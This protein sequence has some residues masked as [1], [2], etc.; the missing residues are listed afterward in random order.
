MA[1]PDSSPGWSEVVSIAR[2]Y[3]RWLCVAFLLPVL[4]AV[5]YAFLVT[6][7]YQADSKVLIR[8]GREYEPHLDGAGRNVALPT[9]TMQEAIE[10]E[11]Q[12]LNSRDLLRRVIDEV[13][14][15]RLYPQLA[16][17]ARPSGVAAEFYALL[18]HSIPVAWL[19]KLAREP[20]HA[21]S[22][23]QTA[24]ERASKALSEDLAVTPV[25]MSNVI[26]ISLRNRN[27]TVALQGL[28]RVL[29]TFERLHVQAFRQQRSW[30]LSE[31]ITKNLAQLHKL[32]A[33]RAAYQSQSR[34]FS[35]PE[36]RTTLIRERAQDSHDLQDAE[37]QQSGL[38]AQIGFLKKEIAALPKSVTLS[39]T[40]QEAPTLSDA[41]GS[42][43][44]LKVQEHQLASLYRSG[45]GVLRKTR[46]AIA[47][48]EAAIARGKRFSNAVSVGINPVLPTLETQ[49]ATA[50]AALTPLNTKIATLKQAIAEKDSHLSDLSEAELRLLDLDR[51][52]QQINL[53]TNT[54]RQRL[55]DA[56]FVDD[57][58]RADIASIHVIQRPTASIYPVFP[59]KRLLA[60]GGVA[61]GVLLSGLVLLLLL[62]FRK[63]FITPS[64]AERM[65]GLPILAIV[66]VPGP[67]QFNNRLLPPPVQ[68]RSAEEPSQ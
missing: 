55:V 12:I 5:G 8:A 24:F 65:L 45:S 57:L 29:S 37:I 33:Q 51:Q 58:D 42:L 49:L 41:E 13:T 54:L 39:T 31:Q 34:L 9:T 27:R 56:R 61:A 66:A 4:V 3:R 21:S 32:E 2:R 18:R 59:K 30:L 26:D 1:F 43:R 67:Q 35:V 50:G 47:A 19:M 62:T 28:G 22:A 20:K 25:K 36:Q 64:A 7:V 17:D 53:A 23:E 40:N 44:Q 11:V 15:K 60:A 16:K 46:A 63:T 38:R 48:T 6:P 52:I 10:S 14:L 68:R